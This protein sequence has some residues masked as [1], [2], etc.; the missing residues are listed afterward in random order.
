MIK[1]KYLAHS[2]FLI[3]CGN[4]KLVLD[5]WLKGPAYYKQWFLWPLPVDE[6]GALDVDAI[7]ISHGHEDHLH[8]ETLKAMKKNAEV[9]FSFQWRAGIKP[10]LNHLGFETITEAVN[11]KT[12]LINDVKITYI[13]FSLESVIVIEYKNEVVVNVNDALNSNHEN[14]VDFILKEINK[15]WTKI[16]YVLSGWSGASYFPNQIR[17]PGKDDIE[18][19]KLR[20]QYFAN[21]FCRFVEILKPAVAIPFASGFVL[22]NKE[23][24]WINHI[25]FSRK[26]VEDYYLNEFGSK[27]PAK[28]LIPYPG[29]TI[30][31]SEMEEISALHKIEEDKQHDLA[32]EHYAAEI[33][34][35]DKIILIEDENI[36]ELVKQ[37]NTWA[38]FNKKLYH[39]KVIE[40]VCFSIKLTDAKEE[41]FINVHFENKRL[42][43]QRSIIPIQNSKLLINT[44]GNKMLFGFKKIWGGDV[45]TIGYGLVVEVYDQLTLEKNM[46]IVCIRLVTRYPIARQD[47]LKFPLRAL[48]FYSF[49]PKITS[50]WLKQKIVLKPYVNKYPYNERDHWLTYNKCNLCAVCK[51]PEINLEAYSK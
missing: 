37:I 1:L 42:H 46:D 15:R 11:F 2:S 36:D 34:E 48:K 18:I 39:P 26:K 47:L 49:N 7:L 32:Y 20:E 5:P 10:F 12:Y 28:F 35:A 22:L 24:K 33:K 3:T 29:D 40:D 4:T 6:P 38:N 45:L 8:S 14:A 27:V 16:D 21:N 17:Y 9:F 31:N 25:K 44:S 23:N 43:A 51:M 30:E 41:T 13:S 50:L 19:G